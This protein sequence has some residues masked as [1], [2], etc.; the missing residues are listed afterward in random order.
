VDIIHRFGK[1]DL[2]HSSGVP[3][4]EICAASQEGSVTETITIMGSS[5]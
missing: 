3:E 5:E 2:F 1:L 4:S